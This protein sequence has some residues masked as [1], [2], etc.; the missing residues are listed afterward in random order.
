MLHYLRVGLGIIITQSHTHTMQ[1]TRTH[2]AVTRCVE[3]KM[4]LSRR[5]Q[6]KYSCVECESSLS[7]PHGQINTMIFAQFMNRPSSHTQ[8]SHFTIRHATSNWLR[9]GQNSHYI[10][11]KC[12]QTHAAKYKITLEP[13]SNDLKMWVKRNQTEIR[14]KIT[15]YIHNRSIYFKII[16]CIILG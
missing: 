1:Q 8:F 2:K 11:G 7:S 9:R 12:R 16:T 13:V 15:I 6:S 14:N 5:R 10:M 3:A 4:L